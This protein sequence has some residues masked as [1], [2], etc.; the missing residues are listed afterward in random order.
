MEKKKEKKK[1][2]LYYSK[3]IGSPRMLEPDEAENF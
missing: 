1:S 2:F 3:C